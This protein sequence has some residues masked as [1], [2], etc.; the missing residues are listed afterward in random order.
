MYVNHSSMRTRV[1]VKQ[2]MNENYKRM[3]SVRLSG[4]DMMMINDLLRMVRLPLPLPLLLLLV[5]TTSTTHALTSHSGTVSGGARLGL[6]SFDLDDTLFCTSTVVQDANDVML[7]H[8]SHYECDTSVAEFQL[9]TRTIRQRLTEPITYTELRKRAI[10]AEMERVTGQTP[11]H[12]IVDACFYAW[13]DERNVSAGK[14]LFPHTVQSLQKILDR[15]PDICIGAITNG[16]GNPLHID[17]LKHFFQFCVS[18]EDDDVFPARKPSP[19]IY[20]KALEVYRHTHRHQLDDTDSYLWIHVGDCLAN[21]VG[22]SAALGAYPVWYAPYH[23]ESERTVA[24]QQKSP[25]KQPFYSTASQ[26]DLQGRARLA[27]AA[28]EKV[29]ARIQSF[30]ELPDTIERILQVSTRAQT[31]VHH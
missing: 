26:E 12:E 21:D 17:P 19:G 14:N 2:N 11:S 28:Q 20:K 23:V 6:L 30:E 9:T 29:A 31:P 27:E 5:G 1:V 4:N 10:C 13:L 8:L 18:G 7:Q 25:A 3:P 22:A 15:L 16:R 24:M